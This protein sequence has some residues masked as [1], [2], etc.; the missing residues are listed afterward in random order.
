VNGL[1]SQL[2]RGAKRFVN[3]GVGIGVPVLLAGVSTIDVPVTCRKPPTS[4]KA[5]S[6]TRLF[7][8]SP[9]V[10]VKSPSQVVVCLAV[11][12]VD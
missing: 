8:L 11:V 4:N 12:R 3:L 2:I 1:V 9:Q 6:L 10:F 5:D 7:L